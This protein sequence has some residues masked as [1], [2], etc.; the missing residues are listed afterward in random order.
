MEFVLAPYFSYPLNSL[1]PNSEPSRAH[2][3]LSLSFSAIS[4]SP[5]PCSPPFRRAYLHLPFPARS[6][7]GLRSRS[8][9]DLAP[10]WIASN[11]R[12]ILPSTSRFPTVY[13]YMGRGKKI[14][15]MLV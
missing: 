14:T 6:S 12:C 10:V 11:L 7:L 15:N 4:F 3:P 2:L 5:H 8:P 9:F 1:T 13:V